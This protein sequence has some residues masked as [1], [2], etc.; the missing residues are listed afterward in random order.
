MR[1]FLQFFY[2]TATFNAFDSFCNTPCFTRTVAM[3]AS[4]F[5]YNKFEPENKTCF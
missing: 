1:N 3:F 4:A 5:V 2:Y